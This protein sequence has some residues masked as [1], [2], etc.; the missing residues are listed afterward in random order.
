MRESVFKRL[1]NEISD[2]GLSSEFDILTTTMSFTHKGTGSEII[3]SGVDDVEKLKSIEKIT[4]VWVEEATELTELEFDQ[5][6]LRL[7]GETQFYKQIILTFNPIDESHWLKKRFFDAPPD[8]A[9]VLKTTFKDNAFIDE[10]YRK[11][12]E[13][14]AAISPNLY[15]I[16]Y[17]GEWGREDIESPYCINFKKEKHV[18]EVAQ[19]KPEMQVIFSLDF[20]VEP[21]VCIAAHKWADSNGEH[22]H[23]FDEIVIEKN[24]SVPA[25]CDKLE[26][27][28][29]AQVMATCLFTGDA[30][31]RKREIVHRDNLDAWR[32]IEARFNAG[33]RMRVPSANP[34][35]SDNRHLINAVMA[36]H[37]DM[38]I[39]PA[40]TKLIYDCQFV[41][42]D[43]EGGI[44]KK[45]RNKQEQRSDAMDCFVGETLIET[46]SGSKRIDQIKLGDL[47][48]TR[49]GHKP[50]VDLWSSDA[51]V[52][53]YTFEDGTKITCTD[54]HKFYVHGFG[55]HAIFDIFMSNK[56]TWKLQSFT[57]EETTKNT[58]SNLTIIAGKARAFI[59][60]A[61]IGKNGL[62]L[63][64]KYLKDMNCTM[65]TAMPI[66]MSYQTMNSKRKAF[67]KVNTVS[68]GL[69]IIQKHL[70]GLLKLAESMLKPGTVAPL[71]LS[72]T[73]KT[74]STVGLETKLMGKG[75]ANNVVP[76]MK[77]EHISKDFA[78]I[79]ASRNGE[80]KTTPILFCQTVL[81]AGPNIA[82]SN[83]SQKN[84]VAQ[85]AGQP[86]T[87]T[88]V[89]VINRNEIG[90]RKVYDITVAGEHEFYANGV[91]VHNCMRYLLN[92]FLRDFYE[93][94]KIK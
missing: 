30:M 28:Y 27:I 9:Y 58:K 73:G 65:R 2:M 25:M 59:Q 29:G 10:E 60:S 87:H 55:F 37:P 67:T 83:T 85:S 6:D 64:A 71:V 62:M 94:Y 13:Q 31:Q 51:N 39:N 74:L 33:R 18:S 82:P 34:K 63:M 52:S 48:L 12:L 84:I 19:F 56:K 26:M 14:K 47:V 79:I 4:S 38:K 43:A 91:L 80:E 92:T 81:S 3:L 36:Y 89:R 32:M 70:K 21:F 46:I 5:I 75:F 78:Q 15:R 7:R 68:K 23:I 22:L 50:V 54:K 72:G 53:E 35:V 8:N 45:D 61:Y 41:E 44:I 40:C 49:N 42:A 77:P 57:T 17:L 66:T 88:A 11:V 93:R 69:K 16:Y 90:L 20:N 24:G 76:N 86:Q 1:K